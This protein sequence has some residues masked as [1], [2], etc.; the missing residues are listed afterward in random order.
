MTVAKSWTW[1]GSQ[2]ASVTQHSEYVRIC[3]AR[4]VNIFSVLNMPD[5]KCGSILNMQELRRVLD[6]PQY[7]WICLNRTWICLNIYEFL[8]ID[9]VLNKHYTIYSTRSL[10]KLMSNYWEMGVFRNRSKIK[11][12]HF[13]KIIIDFNYFCKKLKP[14]S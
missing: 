14:K 1:E 12:E 9:R 6:M 4:V 10:Y 5:S 7:G 8:I 11:M 13:G 3:L 2:Y